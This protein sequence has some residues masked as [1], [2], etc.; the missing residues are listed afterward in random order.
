MSKAVNAIARM[1]TFELLFER[2]A[3]LPRWK[4]NIL[5]G[6]L[7]ARLAEFCLK[8]EPRCSG[9][10]LLHDCPYGYLIRTPSKGVVLRKLEAV[11]KPLV[12]KPPLD[13]SSG[14]RAGSALTFSVVLF[15]DAVR[16]EKHLLLAVSQMAKNGLGR[17][18]KRSPL[19]LIRAWVENPFTHSK[20]LIY[21]NGRLYSSDTWIREQDVILPSARVYS[22]T[23][24][25]PTRILRNGALVTR[26]TLRDLIA[27]AMRRYTTIAAQYMLKKPEEALGRRYSPSEI[28][29]RSERARTLALEVRRVWLVYKGEKE[30]YISGRAIYA[31]DLTRAQR[32]ILGFAQLSHVGKR[33]SYGH[34]WIKVEAVA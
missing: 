29:E 24:L 7:A 12:L 21:E 11:S 30:E 32:K 23:F 17:R 33:A 28:L 18:E 22:V 19:R 15:G 1:Y 25:T 9:C 31:A 8:G 6:A 26:P 10:E 20:S 4:G 13:Y 2:D 16:F 27:A 14:V 3:E 34:G 5:R